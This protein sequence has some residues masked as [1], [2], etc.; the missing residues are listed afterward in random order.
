[1][2]EYDALIGRW[3][4]NTPDDETTLKRNLEEERQKGREEV[5]HMMRRIFLPKSKEKYAYSV[6]QAKEAFDVLLLAGILEKPLDDVLAIDRKLLAEVKR[7]TDKLRVGDE[8]EFYSM[9]DSLFKTG[10]TTKRKGYVIEVDPDGEKGWVRV[11]L[12]GDGTRI[13]ETS[14]CK[15]TGTYNA[16]IAKAMNTL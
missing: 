2:I 11:L 9:F 4:V 5:W 10:E 13:V 12:K 7:E 1:M 6:E 15:K 14:T 16:V 3:V 8:V